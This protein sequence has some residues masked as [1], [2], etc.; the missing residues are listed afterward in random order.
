MGKL[1][2]SCVA[3]IA[4][5]GG[6]DKTSSCV[7]GTLTGLPSTLTTNSGTVNTPGPEGRTR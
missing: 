5:A 1:S 6:T 3:G 7:D 4:V 2:V